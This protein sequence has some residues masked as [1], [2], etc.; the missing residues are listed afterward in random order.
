MPPTR[1]RVLIVA[2]SLDIL[3]GQAVQADRLY[4][5]LSL[6]PSL[7][8]N[9]LAVNPHLP[10]SLRRLKY[11][12]TLVAEAIYIAQ[13]V[14]AVKRAEVLHV[15]SA[16]Y[17]SFLLAPTPALVLGRWAGCATILNYRSGE[18]EDHFRRWS[19]ARWTLRLVDQIVVPSGYLADVFRRFGFN[20][21]AVQNVID[22]SLF[23]FRQRSTLLPRFITNRNLEPMYNVAMVLRAFE[24]IQSAVPDATLWIAG[25]GSER[26]SLENLA[27]QLKLRGVSFL[28]KVGVTEMPTCLDRCDIYLNGSDIDNMPMSLVEAFACGLPVVSTDAGGIPYIVTHERNGLLVD[29]NDH[30]A[31]AKAALRL[32]LE[33]QFAKTLVNNASDSCERYVWDC[34]RQQWVDLYHRVAE[35]A[36]LRLN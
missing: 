2:P 27:S 4:R 22:R 1:T 10:A 24:Q 19:T 7:E 16:A 12:R 13:L 34:V 6:E 32:L 33:P 8:V 14:P 5:N 18:A 21:Q 29:C 36:R 35:Q 28:G 31:M 17:W 25:E 26:A 23:R 20:A 11:L 15:F 9:F 3:G 30:N